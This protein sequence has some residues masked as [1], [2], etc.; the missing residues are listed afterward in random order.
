MKAIEWKQIGNYSYEASS[1]GQ[2]RNKKTGRILTQRIDKDYGYKLVDIQIDKK[3]KTFKAHRLI[4]E[5]FFG[6]I[7]EGLQVDHINRIKTD[8]R[9][10]NLRVV[11]PIVNMR[12]RTVGDINESIVEVIVNLYKEGKSFNEICLMVNKR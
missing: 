9:I 6:S 7:K 1:D 2:V 11:T 5:A 3:N 8:N 12:N 10:E 4:V